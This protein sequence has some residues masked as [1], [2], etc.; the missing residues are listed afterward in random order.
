MTPYASLLYF[1]VSLYAVFPV[2]LSG[3]I[4]RLK[5]SRLCIVAITAQMLVLQYRNP[6]SFL[7][8]TSVPEYVIVLSYALAQYFIA[9]MLLT[10][11]RHKTSRALFCFAL[12][13]SLVELVATRLMPLSI[14]SSILLVTAPSPCRLLCIRH[15]HTREF[16]QPLCGAQHPRF[17]GPLAHQFVLVV[18]RSCLHAL[19]HGGDSTSLVQTASGCFIHWVR[20]VYGVDGILAWHGTALSD[21]RSL[22]RY[23]FDWI[24]CVLAME[25]TAQ[26][27]KR[28]A[29][30]RRL[31]RSHYA[32]R[33]P[34]Q[35]CQRQ[36]AHDMLTSDGNDRAYSGAKRG[37]QNA[38]RCQRLFTALLHNVKKPRTS[39]IFVA[40][41]KCR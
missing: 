9:R 11:R 6:P 8:G 39:C 3:W 7:T 40:R 37:L 14:S 38:S 5:L 29:W 24:R 25:Q 33:K 22:S 27:I 2:V 16:P 36:S 35:T 32:Q 30:E 23:A 18:S 12:A 17:L 20:P 41:R 28:K 19:C 1:S 34:N 21:L 31:N 10:M 4:Q 13:L 26:S 15:S